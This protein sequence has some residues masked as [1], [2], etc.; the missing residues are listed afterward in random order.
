MCPR[1]ISDKMTPFAVKLSVDCF[2]KREA[3]RG[4]ES[5]LLNVQF[6]WRLQHINAQL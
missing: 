1:L 6:F 3:K 5:V 4:G 2:L